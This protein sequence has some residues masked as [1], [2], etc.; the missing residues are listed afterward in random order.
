[1]GNKPVIVKAANSFSCA[2]ILPDCLARISHK[3][4]YKGLSF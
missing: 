4:V 3:G 2:L 1:M